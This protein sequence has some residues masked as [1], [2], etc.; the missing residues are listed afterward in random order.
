MRDGRR[1]RLFEE[2]TLKRIFWSKRD[3]VT[4]EW[5]KLHN[6]ELNDPYDSSPN[7]CRII[8]SRIIRR[9]KNVALCGTVEVHTGF[10]LGKSEEKRQFGRLRLRGEDNIEMD[11]QEVR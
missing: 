10:W 6:E 3:E 4:E 2:T 7:L 1:L 9:D 8:K 11:L 5:R